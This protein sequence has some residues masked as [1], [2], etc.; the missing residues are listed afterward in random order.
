[1]SKKSSSGGGLA[2]CIQ[3]G[4]MHFGSYN[5]PYLGLATCTNCRETIPEEPGN[6]YEIHPGRK[7]DVL[8]KVYHANCEF[9]VG[10]SPSEAATNEKKLEVVCVALANILTE[11][12]SWHTMHDHGRS[13]VQCDAICEQIP[14]MKK[15]LELART[16]S[17]GQGSTPDIR[18]EQK[19]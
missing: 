9:V 15:A 7:F 19:R 6:N 14:A 3:C 2:A 5:C 10:A 12:E 16:S 18:G 13:S 17:S 1:M 8:G 11:A 4:G